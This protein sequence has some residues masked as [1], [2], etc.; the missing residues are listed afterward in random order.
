MNA[1]VS[2]GGRANVWTPWAALA[3]AAIA[4]AGSLLLLLRTGRA[5][6]RQLGQLRDAATRMVSGAEPPKPPREP[7]DGEIAQVYDAISTLG[8]TLRQT[9]ANLEAQVERERDVRAMLELLQGHIVR[10]E[11]LAA[12]G[13]LLSGVAH[14]LNN[15]LQAIMGGAELLERRS[16]FAADV[17]DEVT[18]ISTQAQRAAEIV[19]NLSRFGA[20]RPALPAAIDPRDVI[21]EVVQLRRTDLEAAGIVWQVH[22]D[23]TGRVFASFTEIEQVLLNFV[24]N[25]QQSITSAGVA[26]GLI[27]IRSSDTDGLVRLEVTD[28][29]PGVLPQDEAK[30][31]QPFFTTKPFGEGTGLGLSVS[32]K[33]IESYGGTVGYR[34]NETGDATFYFELPRL[35]ESREQA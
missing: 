3:L 4:V 25:A 10:Q 5:V 28:N 12:V 30:L 18:L 24:I 2:A 23:S 29:G 14:E 27:V 7:L 13:L 11:R 22:T 15:P 9:Q 32:H 17:R 26:D 19:R 31:F 8:D 33:I 20:Q 21:S 1:A 34:R 6:S 35:D 16:D